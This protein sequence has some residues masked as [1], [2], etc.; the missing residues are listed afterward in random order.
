MTVS[1]ICG[2]ITARGI[3]TNAKAGLGSAIACAMAR[4]D[5]LFHRVRRG[6]YRLKN[7]DKVGL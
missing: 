1:E 4:R 7:Q 3:T 5:D 6:L 2:M